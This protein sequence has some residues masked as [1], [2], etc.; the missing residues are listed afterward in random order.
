MGHHRIVIDMVGGHGCDRTAVEGEPR[1]FCGSAS[2]PDCAARALV[3]HFK[4]AGA[5]GSSNHAEAGAVIIHWPGSISEVVDDL[6][7]GKRAKGSFG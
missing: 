6:L 5:F 2:C 7:T 4:R 1:M 3:E